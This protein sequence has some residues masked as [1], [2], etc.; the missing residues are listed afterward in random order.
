MMCHRIGRPPISTIG[1]GRNSVSSRNRVPSPPHRMTT[2]IESLPTFWQHQSIQTGWLTT[3]PPSIQPAG[4]SRRTRKFGHSHWRITAFVST[5]KYQDGPKP[6]QYYLP[7]AHRFRIVDKGHQ[8]S[9]FP[10][11]SDL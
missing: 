11:E 1:F 9:H 7:A 3:A 8:V 4:P 2:F 10:M 5:P 6:R